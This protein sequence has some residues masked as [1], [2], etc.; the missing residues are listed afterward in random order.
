MFEAT[1]A[2]DKSAIDVWFDN[3][4]LVPLCLQTRRHK[5][6]PCA[7]V[8][9]RA[10]WRMTR[11]SSGNAAVTVSEPERILLDIAEMRETAFRV[12]NF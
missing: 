6:G 5:A 11:H 9:D 2:S 8:D 10:V 1:P 3:N 7:D 12:S 4:D